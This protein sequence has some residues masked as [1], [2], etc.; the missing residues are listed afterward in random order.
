MLNSP[1]YNVFLSFK[2]LNDDDITC[3]I[4]LISEIILDQA[5]L[6]LLK[7]NIHH[8]L[9]SNILF[10]NALKMFYIEFVELIKQ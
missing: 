7:E 5:Y 10:T 2:F 6:H 8:Y 3:T 1:K 9:L 4:F